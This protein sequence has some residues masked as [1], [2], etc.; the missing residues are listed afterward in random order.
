MFNEFTFYS[1]TLGSHAAYK[2]DSDI[3]YSLSILQ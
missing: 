1:S 2:A 3:L